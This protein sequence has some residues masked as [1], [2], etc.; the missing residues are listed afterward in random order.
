MKWLFGAK[1]RT[2]DSGLAMIDI[3]PD[4]LYLSSG[5]IVYMGDSET[6]SSTIG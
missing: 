5:C 2:S 3:Q 1:V 4:R 6:L